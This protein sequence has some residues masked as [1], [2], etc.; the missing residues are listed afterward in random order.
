V[1]P[2]EKRQRGGLYYTRSRK[3]NGTV[4]REYVG[5]GVLGQLAALAALG[6]FLDNPAKGFSYGG[7]PANVDTF[8]YREVS[9]DQGLD[10]LVR[11]AELAT[12]EPDER[13]RLEL[14]R[15]GIITTNAPA[16]EG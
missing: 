10:A 13:H 3:E 6:S 2:W 1:S 14:E 5:G 12:V 11:E 4:V 9:V 15:A 8:Q 16:W 7:G